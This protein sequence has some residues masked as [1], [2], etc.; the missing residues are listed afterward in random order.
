MRV[1]ADS[2]VDQLM[3][4]NHY[5]AVHQGDVIDDVVDDSTLLFDDQGSISETKY[6]KQK[7]S[8]K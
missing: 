6:T 2:M 7:S 1:D 4:K 3:K 8:R 5:S